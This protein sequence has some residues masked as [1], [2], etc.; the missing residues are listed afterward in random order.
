ML[1][2]NF[3]KYLIVIW[4]FFFIKNYWNQ[5]F[6]KDGNQEKEGLNL[7]SLIENMSIQVGFF[8]IYC[9]TWFEIINCVPLSNLSFSSLSNFVERIKLFCENFWKLSKIIFKVFHKKVN[10]STFFYN[11]NLYIFPFTNFF[12]FFFYINDNEIVAFFNQKL[13]QLI[14]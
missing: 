10:R 7:M 5:Y 11:E 9:L 8:W 2:Y 14:P 6:I 12:L 13:S 1:W 3:K 4:I